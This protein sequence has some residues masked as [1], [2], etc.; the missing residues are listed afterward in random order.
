MLTLNPVQAKIIAT[1]SGEV[2]LGDLNHALI[3]ALECKQ[4]SL[5][6]L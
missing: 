4:Q 6:W 2:E 3:Y 1:T 5:P